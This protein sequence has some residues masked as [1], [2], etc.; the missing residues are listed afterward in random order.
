MFVCSGV[1]SDQQYWESVEDAAV[2][3]QLVTAQEVPTMDQIGG[4][5]PTASRPDRA[6]MP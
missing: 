3:D 2:S 6:A 4:G 5:L 1:I